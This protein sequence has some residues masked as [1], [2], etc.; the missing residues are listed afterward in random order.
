[1]SRVTLRERFF[2]LHQPADVER[3]LS[4]FPWWVI[5]KAGTSDKTF[6]AWA[7]VQDA[8]TK[9]GKQVSDELKTGK[10]SASNADKK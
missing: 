3:F 9:A 8:L 4:D 5:F 7:V 6:D 10:L 1:M 2:P